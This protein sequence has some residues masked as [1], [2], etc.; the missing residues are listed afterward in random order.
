MGKYDG[1]QML[2]F[3]VIGLGLAMIFFWIN[4]GLV[5]AYH[6]SQYHRTLD[7]NYQYQ[8][9]SACEASVQGDENGVPNVT[10]P[11]NTWTCA[12]PKG[13]VKN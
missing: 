4:F 7:T 13:E 3:G 8:Y 9:V 5:Y 1:P 10:G 6:T 2:G 12:I 11:S